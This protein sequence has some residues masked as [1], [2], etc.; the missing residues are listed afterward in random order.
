MLV[1]DFSYLVDIWRLIEKDP[2][3]KDVYLSKRGARVDGMHVAA[4]RKSPAPLPLD[5]SI[6]IDGAMLSGTLALM[7]QDAE[8]TVRH[9][10]ASLVLSAKGRRV[11]LRMRVGKPSPKK[12]R[13]KAKFFDG[14]ALRDEIA[15]LRACT[16]G[17]VVQPLLTGI[18][19]I[20]EGARVVLEATD[21]ERRTGRMALRLPFTATGHVVPGTDL[22]MALVL[23]APEIAVK[24]I[25]ARMCLQDAQTIIQLSILYGRFPDLSRLPKPALYQHEIMLRKHQLET[26]IKAA[27]ILD[28]DRLVILAIKDKR[29]A[30]LVRG[31]EVGGFRQ[32]VGACDL[33]D[34]EIVFD[35]HWLDAAQY[36]G[37]HVKLRY[38]DHR[39][40]VLFSGN[41]RLLWMSP[42]VKA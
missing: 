25:E 36:V 34:I 3:A 5:G 10:P 24:F 20:S 30:L 42:I 27:V 4:F 32:P 29:A 33:P 11:V 15:F 31:Q 12:L 13:F 19:F 41:K 9:T 2:G 21:A 8:L 18:H 40:P 26:A 22:E 7:P 17:G 16:S 39:S 38:T 1:K 23:L 28:N 35:A 6:S 14:T 37:D